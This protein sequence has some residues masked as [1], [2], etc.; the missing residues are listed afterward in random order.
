MSSSALWAW[1]TVLG[2][3]DSAS[4]REDSPP[5]HVLSAD[6]KASCNLA[7]ALNADLQSMLIV[8]RVQTFLSGGKDSETCIGSSWGI[9]DMNSCCLQ[10][11]ATQGWESVLKFPRACKGVDVGV[12][13]QVQRPPGACVASSLASCPCTTRKA[14]FQVHASTE[15]KPRLGLSRLLCIAEGL[16][17]PNLKYQTSSA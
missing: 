9:Q 10:T 14:T 1:S 17:G 2:L 5:Y 7:T 13:A 15:T 12:V 3:P 11:A 8:R 4:T 6:G 16:E